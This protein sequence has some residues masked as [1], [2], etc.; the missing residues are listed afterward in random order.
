MRR[1]FE[2]AVLFFQRAGVPL[3][4]DQEIAVEP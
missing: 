1:D 3:E 2:F 4:N